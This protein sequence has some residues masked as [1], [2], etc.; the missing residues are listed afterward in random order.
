MIRSSTSSRSSCIGP[1]WRPGSSRGAHS[2]LLRFDRQAADHGP[3]HLDRP[4]PR[5]HLRSRAAVRHVDAAR[6]PAGAV[7]LRRRRRR[8][9]RRGVQLRQR[10]L[11]R[12]RDGRVDAGH[13]GDDRHDR[14]DRH[15]RR[16]AAT[17][18]R[19]P[20]A[21]S[22]PAA[23]R[24]RRRRPARSRATAPTAS[25]SSPRA[26]SCASDIRASFGPST[27]V[28][29]GVP[30]THRSDDHRHRRRLRTTRRRRRVRVALRPRR[31]LL[32]VL[33][34]RR[35]RELPARRA[36][37]RR[38]RSGDVHEHLPGVLLGSLAAHPLRGVPEPRRGDERRQQGRHVTAGPARRTP[39]TSCTPPRATSRA[40]ATWARC[41]W[42]RDNV[43]S[44]DGAAQQLATM[45]GSVADGYTAALALAI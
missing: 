19:R 23:R 8:R 9:A 14:H 43:F 17:P 1:F 12:R 18:A 7:A 6:P 3:D 37:D 26:G 38:R 5:R 10:R 11:R 36:G 25:T 13:H 28:A 40:C 15:D 2:R 22:T 41:R 30:L 4:R 39:A 27:T 21:T 32:D 20:T 35:R 29:E 24:S 42:R 45:S 34:R 31:Q 44:D 16:T 33:R